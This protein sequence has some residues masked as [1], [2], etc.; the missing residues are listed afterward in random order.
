MYE[1]LFNEDLQK[2]MTAYFLNELAQ[3]GTV[4]AFSKNEIVDPDESDH[5]YIVLDG[6]FNQVLYS[7]DG[8]EISFFR[9][10]KGTIFGEMDYFD[11]YRTCIIT[12]ALKTSAVS[13]VPRSVLE[14]EIAKTPDIYKQ[15]MHSVIRKFRIVMLELAD[16]KFN[17]SLGKLAHALVRMVYTTGYKVEE[18]TGKSI[19][20]M[21]LTHEEL[22]SRLAS[23]RSTITNGLNY[24][25]EKGYIVIEDKKICIIDP[26]GLKKYINPY[27][28]D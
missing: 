21:K 26:E 8:D 3:L 16:V 24:F 12:K 17:D 20:N 19:I 18:E 11:G 13:I 10:E 25:K 9:L 22:A 2:Q 5:V 14:A 1:Q 4:K 7:L 23:N 15:F 27:W 28:E 6:A